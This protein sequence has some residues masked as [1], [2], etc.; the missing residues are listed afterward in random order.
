[1]EALVDK[2]ATQTF[3]HSPPSTSPSIELSIRKIYAN[4]RGNISHGNGEEEVLLYFPSSRLR[5]TLISG[6]ELL[7]FGVL[8][9]YLHYG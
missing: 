9:L 4:P 8:Q 7:K 2:Q 6:G 3:Y 5:L 1:M